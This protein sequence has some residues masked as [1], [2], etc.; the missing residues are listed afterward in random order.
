M[1]PLGELSHPGA[2]NFN[3]AWRELLRWNGDHRKSCVRRKGTVAVAK[4]NRKSAVGP[5][6]HD[7][8][9]LA[10]LVEIARQG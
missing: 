5:V 6:G 8:V 1:K 9:S 3:P 2:I 7:K 10:I 4:Q